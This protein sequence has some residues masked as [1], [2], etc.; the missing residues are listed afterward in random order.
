[1]YCKVEIDGRWRPGRGIGT[2]A[3]DLNPLT[4][5][6]EELLSMSFGPTY[7]SLHAR[8]GTAVEYSELAKVLARHLYGVMDTDGG[9]GLIRYNLNEGGS[10]EFGKIVY[11]PSDVLLRLDD[12]ELQELRELLDGL[13]AD[14]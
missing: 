6:G 9:Y 2:L 7:F 10:P 3:A 12:H 14:R 1:M 11:T 13:E 5:M 4:D 8:G